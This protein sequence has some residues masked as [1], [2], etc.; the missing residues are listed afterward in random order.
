MT[1]PNLDRK[2]NKEYLSFIDNTEQILEIYK[3]VISNHFAFEDQK[4]LHILLHEYKDKSKNNTSILKIIEQIQMVS[5]LK[6][7]LSEITNIYKSNF[8]LFENTD[9]YSLCYLIPPHYDR[10]TKSHH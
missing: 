10:S 9:T 5:G 6:K 8:A 4:R 1:I 3:A 2:M 7:S